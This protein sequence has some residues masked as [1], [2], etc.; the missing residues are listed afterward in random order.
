MHLSSEQFSE[1][2]VGPP[3]AAAARHLE[4]CPACRAELANFCEALNEFR[5]AVRGWSQREAQAALAIPAR[6]PDTRSWIASHQFALV[7]L[8]AAVCILA[9]VAAPWYQRHHPA[10]A[11][12]AALLNQ[13]DAQISRTAPSSLEPLM[14]LVVERQQ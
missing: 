7:L 14:K 11:N 9:S 6:A 8:L 1:C 12:D 2:I 3:G 10:T 13:V 4:G 5:G